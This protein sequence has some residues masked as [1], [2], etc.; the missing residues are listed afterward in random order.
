[1]KIHKTKKEA[2]VAIKKYAQTMKKACEETGAYW[3][4]YASDDT[5]MEYYIEA[6]YRG[7]PKKRI[8]LGKEKLVPTAEEIRIHVQELGL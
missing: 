5:G 3:A 7:K 8:V 6:C 2:V 1:M 4:A